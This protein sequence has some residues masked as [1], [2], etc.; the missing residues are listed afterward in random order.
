MQVDRAIAVVRSM[1]ASQADWLEMEKLIA[2]AAGQGD[3]VAASIKSFKLHTNH[4][5][6]LLQ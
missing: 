3:V 5:V 1:L 6:M 4:I 2:E